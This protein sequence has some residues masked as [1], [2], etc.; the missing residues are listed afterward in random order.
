M[1]REQWYSKENCR[2]MAHEVAPEILRKENINHINVKFPSLNLHQKAASV[3][4]LDKGLTT[5]IF[6]IYFFSIVLRHIGS[7]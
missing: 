5:N 7:L 1:G 4:L 2:K 6:K 3:E